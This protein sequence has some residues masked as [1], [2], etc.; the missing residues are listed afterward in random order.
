M[1]NSDLTPFRDALRS[2]AHRE[3]VGFVDYSDSRCW[4]EPFLWGP[5]P[6]LSA[7]GSPEMEDESEHRPDFDRATWSMYS[8]VA[9][10]GRTIGFLVMTGNRYLAIE[11]SSAPPSRRNEACRA[12][13]AHHR[14]DLLVIDVEA[15][16][17]NP[18]QVVSEFFEFARSPARCT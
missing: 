18:D 12:W 9:F 16:K 14:M 7:D 17:A 2:S 6:N 11:A 4:A 1:M 8:D 3:S 5:G 10:E 15:L 13:L